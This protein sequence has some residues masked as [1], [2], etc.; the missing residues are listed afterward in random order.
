ML[1]EP[2]GLLA[3][4]RRISTN[5]RTLTIF[6]PLLVVAFDLASV[7]S[8]APAVNGR[9]LGLLADLPAQVHEGM[10]R[11]REGMVRES[12]GSRWRRQASRRRS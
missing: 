10:V 2:W 3:R 9:R 12:Q 8:D 7:S 6:R 11:V 4:G 1:I 5:S